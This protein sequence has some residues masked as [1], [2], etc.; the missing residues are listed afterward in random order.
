M[1]YGI[2]S[3][4]VVKENRM[5][6]A[7]HVAQVREKRTS[8]LLVGRLEGKRTLGRRRRRW[9]DNIKMDLLE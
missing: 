6:W 7:G 4:Y 1:A 2:M 3:S 5:R 8:T 9:M